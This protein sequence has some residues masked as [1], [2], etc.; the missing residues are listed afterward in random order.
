VINE[1]EILHSD[2]RRYLV[3]WHGEPPDVT[4]TA[5]TSEMGHSI[6]SDQFSNFLTTLLQNLNTSDAA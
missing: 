1:T 2:G 6:D 5:I 3:E 4:I